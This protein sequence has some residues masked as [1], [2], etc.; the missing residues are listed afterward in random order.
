VYE[1]ANSA[2]VLIPIE[3][4]VDYPKQGIPVDLNAFELPRTLIRCKPDWH[5]AEVVAPR[6]T[7]YYKSTRALGYLYRNVQLDELTEEQK[8]LSRSTFRPL[9][10]AISLRLM[11]FM[12][13]YIGALHTNPTGL[14]TEVEPI[15]RRY[16]S[17]LNYICVTHTLSNTPGVKLLEAEVVAGTILAKCSQK[18]MRKDRIYRMRTHSEALVKDVQK[19]LRGREE[20]MEDKLEG[21]KRAWRAWEYSLKFSDRDGA[22][23]FGLIA[24]NVIFDGLEGLGAEI[25]SNSKP[26]PK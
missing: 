15:F 3:Q 24:L 10:D 8:K 26:T 16:A 12:R 23:S 4:A 13:E 22:N 2:L 5:A 19:E 11:P 9:T 25:P 7:D 20:S 17:E 21:L 14:F 1:F 18:R 6:D